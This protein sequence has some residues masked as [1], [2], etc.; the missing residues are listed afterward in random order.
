MSHVTTHVLDSSLGRPAAGIEIQLQELDGSP[1]ATGITN[2]DG[3]VPELGPERLAPGAYRLVFAT[4]A[5]F[6]ASSTP[7]FYPSITI[8]FDLADESSHYH[9]PVL[10]SPF[11]YST[12]RGS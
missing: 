8:D 11:A 1:I 6:A 5:Y 10:L 2:A 9:V 12:Y 7:T 4:G 3:R